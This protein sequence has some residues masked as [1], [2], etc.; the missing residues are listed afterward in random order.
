[1]KIGE[2]ESPPK[3]PHFAIQIMFNFIEK[4]SK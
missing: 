3:S 2:G 1:M 4:L